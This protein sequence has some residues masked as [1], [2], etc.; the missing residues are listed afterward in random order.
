MRGPPADCCVVPACHKTQP[1]SQSPM[2]KK[3]QPSPISGCGGATREHG[4]SQCSP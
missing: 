2:L 1:F 3:T 4:Q